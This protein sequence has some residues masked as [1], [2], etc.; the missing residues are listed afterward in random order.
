MQD[1]IGKEPILAYITDLVKGPIPL[2]QLS[3]P[4]RAA[5]EYLFDGD[6]GSTLLSGLFLLGEIGFTPS[7]LGYES[8]T[9]YRL[10][11]NTVK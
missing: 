6:V 3:N 8:S 10:K 1:E 9:Y 2:N 5:G 4:I 7:G 11:R